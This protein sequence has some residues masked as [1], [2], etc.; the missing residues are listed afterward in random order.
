MV[1]PESGAELPTAVSVS[2]SAG[3]GEVVWYLAQRESTTLDV[4]P[5]I[6]REAALSTAAAL[7]DRAER[8]DTAAPSSVRLQVIFGQDNEQQLVWA[9]TFPS[10]AGDAVPGRPSLRILVD[11]RTGEPVSNPA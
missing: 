10:R 7:A 1:A 5:R 8:W 3:S 6:A 11:A 9:V 4:R 2:I